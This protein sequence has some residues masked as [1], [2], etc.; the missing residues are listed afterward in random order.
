MPMEALIT[1]FGGTGYVGRRLV[2]RLAQRGA[3][4]RVVARRMPQQ[5]LPGVE[6]RRGSIANRAAVERELAGASAA[7]NLVGTTAA[8]DEREFFALHCE[9]PRHI[10]EAARRAG[11]TRFVQVSAMGVAKDAPAAADRSKAAG[12][13]AVRE[14]FPDATLVRPALVLGPGNH[15]S[16][17]FAPLVRS[18][19][20]LPLIGGGHT[21]FQPIHVEDLAECM[22]RALERPGA[23]GRDYDLGADEV[24]TLR[25][26]TERLC[27]AI[28][29]SPWLVP[30]PFALAETGAFLTQ[31]LPLAPLT[32]DQARLL[33]TDKVRRAASAGP[34][35]LGVEPRPLDLAA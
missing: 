13:I 12:E 6:Y 26:L 18:L 11:A 22:A 10:A 21:R 28:G 16:A 19:P 29:R 17:R 32:L 23:A 14:A 25:E 31:W 8:A 34:A 15:F 24:L 30:V 4:V 9:A 1:V 7:V 20:A 3:R 27:A 2:E 5:K 33:R 35:D